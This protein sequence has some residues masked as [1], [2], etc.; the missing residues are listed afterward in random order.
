MPIKRL[1]AGLLLS[2][3]VVGGAQ[4]D[5]TGAISRS[6]FQ[7]A[8]TTYFPDQNLGAVTPS[9]VRNAFTSLSNSAYLWVTDTTVARTDEL[10][11]FT[12]GLRSLSNIDLFGAFTSN[13]DYEGLDIAWD[14]ARYHIVTAAWRGRGAVYDLSLAGGGVV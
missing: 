11:T 13:S 14:G 2:C 4:A 10:N 12:L 3:A 8:L 1:V 5:P 9:D 6:A 7:S